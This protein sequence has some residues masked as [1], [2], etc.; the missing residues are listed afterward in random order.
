MP[1]GVVV[2]PAVRKALWRASAK[3]VKPANSNFSNW[4]DLTFARDLIDAGS[5]I[6]IEAVRGKFWESDSEGDCDDLGRQCRHLGDAISESLLPGGAYLFYTGRRGVVG[7][8][9]FF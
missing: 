7:L 8:C 2:A 4:R 3:E 1:S 6:P 9:A 5:S